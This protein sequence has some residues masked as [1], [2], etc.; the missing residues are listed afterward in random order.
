[1]QT[2]CNLV[3]HLCPKIKKLYFCIRYALIIC[4][5]SRYNYLIKIIWMRPE[6]LNI[7]G[8][9]ESVDLPEWGIRHITVKVDTGARRS[10]ID[11]DNIKELGKGKI[12]FD[13]AVDRKNRDLTKT[14]VANILH[15]THVR[16]SNGEQSERYFVETLIAIGEQTRQIE[17]SLI[18]RHQ[19]TYRMLLGR[20]ALEGMFIVD[21]SQ[22][23]IT[24]T[25]KK[26]RIVAT[27]QS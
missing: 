4:I 15:N 20:K 3:V 8:W 23:Y 2:L 1:M 11:V 12:Q 19:M 13:I 6:K 18:S 27:E 21:P 17:L 16:S 25:N 10:A 22:A 14:V 9:K 5:T 24:R 7:I 26:S